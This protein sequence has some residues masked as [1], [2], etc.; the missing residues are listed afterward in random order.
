MNKTIY[1]SSGKFADLCGTT[2]ETLRHYHN[3]G[4]LNPVKQEENGYFYYSVNQCLTF[5]L[6]QLLTQTGN[7]LEEVKKYIDNCSV[8][9]FLILME[10]S[11]NNL[12]ERKNEIEKMMRMIK[13]STNSILENK[14]SSKEISIKK[15][16]EEHYWF[17]DIEPILYEDFNSFL[18]AVYNFKKFN[19]ENN[20]S[21]EHFCTYFISAPNFLTKN[22]LINAMAIKTLLLKNIKNLEKYIHTKS[23]GYYVDVFHKGKPET[24]KNS[25]DKLNDFLAL[26]N[27]KIYSRIYLTEVIYNQVTQNEDDYVMKISVQIEEDENLKIFLND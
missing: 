8:D 17:F 19:K 5:E 2:K 18:P 15:Y 25:L 14:N 13:N 12:V 20:F 27:L 21:P 10:K 26:H 16:E 1:L 7:S 3:K 11:Y 6:I 9:N 24:I 23:K 4:L 22:Y